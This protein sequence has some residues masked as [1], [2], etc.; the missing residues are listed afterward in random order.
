MCKEVNIMTTPTQVR[1]D[2]DVKREASALFATIGLDMSTAVN[3]FLYQ[4]VLRGGLPF[5]IEMPNYNKET[6]QAMM[7]AKKI[8][9]DPSIKGY[10]SVEEA[11]KA[12]KEE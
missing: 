10:S 6:I 9:S 1:I 3:L 8:S 5:N 4:C 11:L 12:L 2:S 7:E